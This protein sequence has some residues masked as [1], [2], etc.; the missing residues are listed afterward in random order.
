MKPKLN[1]EKKS[2]SKRKKFWKNALI[3]FIYSCLIFACLCVSWHWLFKLLAIVLILY[4]KH[5]TNVEAYFRKKNNVITEWFGPPGAG[6][7]TLAACIAQIRADA[8]HIVLSNVDIANTYKLDPVND[9]G[10]YSTY[11]DGKGCSVI[12]DEATLDFDGRGFKSFSATNKN[13]FALFRH[14]QNEVH[15]FSQAVDV[16]KRIRDRTAVAYYIQRSLIPGGFIS[17]RRIKKILIIQEDNK[18]MVD[19]FEFVKFSRRLLF[20]R[21]YWKC[22]DTLDRTMCCKKERVW[23]SWRGDLPDIITDSYIEQQNTEANEKKK[24]YTK[25]II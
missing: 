24:L 9:L 7:T 21:K 23:K 6:K 19:G 4:V 11:F 8:G 14:D 1:K 16:D 10:T 13:Y 3:T 22:F 5:I 25:K 18:Q 20:G 17:I 2:K 15:M 12:I